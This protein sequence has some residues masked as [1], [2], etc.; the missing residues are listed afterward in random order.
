MSDE[1]RLDAGAAIDAGDAGIAKVRCNTKQW[2]KLALHRLDQHASETTSADCLRAWVV[3]AIGEPSH[4]NAWGALFR[5]AIR[6]GVIEDTGMTI[7]SSIKSTHG[8]RIAVY[9]VNGGVL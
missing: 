2:Q 6:C 7:R 1:L 8:R 9:I 4:C 3:D 5:S